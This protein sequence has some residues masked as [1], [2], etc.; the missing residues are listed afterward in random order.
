V[1]PYELIFPPSIQ[2]P[3]M[4]NACDIAAIYSLK[5]NRLVNTKLESVIQCEKEN[6][7]LSDPNL[8][9][10]TKFRLSSIMAKSGRLE[11]QIGLTDYIDHLITNHNKRINKMLI[12]LGLAQHQNPDIFLSNAIGNLAIVATIDKQIVLLKRS[13][14][15]ATF[16][17]YL[18]CPGGH[19]EPNHILNDF[20]SQNIVLEFFDSISREI[21]EELNLTRH[22]LLGVSLIGMMRNLED[23]RKPEMIYYT[24]TS[25]TSD[26]IYNKYKS[27]EKTDFEADDLMI[28]DLKE[29]SHKLLQ[30]T[31]PT[32]VAINLYIN[33]D[34]NLNGTN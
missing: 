28:V 26:E 1:K 29:I 2:K 24:P 10:G 23:G 7:L 14:K 20:N 8:Y 33:L 4:L 34:R 21:I 11:M 12:N 6:L 13:N 25:L 15:V 5:N 3:T 32:W 30:L 17:G 9:P 18:D 31:V 16:R 19:P 27:G 22:D